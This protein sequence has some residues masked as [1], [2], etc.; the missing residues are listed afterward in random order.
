MSHPGC[1]YKPPGPAWVISMFCSRAVT[2]KHVFVSRE[3]I[4]P[5]DRS[6]RRGSVMQMTHFRSRC[7]YM[8]RRSVYLSSAANISVVW[9]SSRLL[10]YL[11]FH[12]FTFRI[13]SILTILHDFGRKGASATVGFKIT[14]DCQNRLYST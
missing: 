11:K 6:V 13:K 7:F 2:Y 14:K 3:V 12:R 10:Q 4:M 8:R 5:L 1:L 9:Y